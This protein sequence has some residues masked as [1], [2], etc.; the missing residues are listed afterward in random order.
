VGETYGYLYF[1]P[2]QAGLYLLGSVTDDPKLAETGKKT[3]AA[4]LG[5]QALIQPLKYVTQRR[6]PD[7]SDRLAFPSA[8]AGAVSSMIPSVYADYGVV[9]ALGVAAS[10]A[11]IGATRLY[12]NAHRL[13]DVL[14]GY[15]IGLGWGLLVETYTRH[16]PSWALLPMSDGPTTLG[17]AFLLQY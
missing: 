10:A 5:A 4:L 1:G 6:R 7:G 9:P 11:F 2:A 14:A 8:H 3:L 17:L 15:A 12:G 16:H 13:S